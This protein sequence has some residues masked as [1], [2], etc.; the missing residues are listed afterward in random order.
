MEPLGILAVF[1]VGVTAGILS[2]LIGIGGGVLIVPFLYFYYAHPALFGAAVRPDLATVVAHA[3]SLFVIVPTSLRGALFFHR[4][5]LVVWR[6]VWP[7]GAA[8]ML[9][10]VAGA[11]LAALLPPGALKVAFGVLLV[12]SAIRLAVR[13]KEPESQTPRPMRLG[14]PVTVGIG[15]VTGLLSALLGVGGGIVAIPLLL[16]VVGIDVRRV[17]ATSIGIIVIT[18]LAG[19][20]AYM[21]SGAGEVGRPAGAVGYVD[22]GVGVVMFLGSLLSVRF[23]TLLNQRLDA[24]ALSF[25]F[26]AIFLVIGVRLVAGNLGLG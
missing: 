3:T 6:A 15:L 23:G 16:H 9:A 24:R 17:A 13:R 20:L 7:I 22:L 10:A 25:L 18:S 8:S 5:K 19:T 11:R 12:F 1:G 26:A 4:A 14:F 2:G 21:V